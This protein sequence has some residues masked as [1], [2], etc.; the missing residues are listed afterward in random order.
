MKKT[1]TLPLLALL[2]PLTFVSTC[3]L[4]QFYYKDI[5]S[6]KLT[7][8]EQS[9]C[10]KAKVKKITLVSLDEQ[11]EPKKDFFCEKKISKDFR[12]N[13]VL[14]RTLIEGKSM[15]STMFNQK[16]YPTQTYDSSEHLVK[17]TIYSY[18][19]D[20]L[21]LSIITESVSKDDDFISTL[22]EAHQYLYDA[23]GKL[24]TL[25]VVIEGKPT[26]QIVFAY[27]ESGNVS[28]E[29]NSTTG[30][31]YYYYYDEQNRL[32]DVV[33]HSDVLEKLVL[34]HQFTYD[35]EGN[36]TRQITTE[37]GR[38]SFIVWKYTYDGSLKSLD[39]LYT[40]KGDL[41]GRIEYSYDRY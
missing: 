3:V 33:H 21:L 40:Q 39:E 4:G 15:M 31:V 34:D 26:N 17:K 35:D 41:L 38:N 12:K 13:T 20:T 2:L 14:T 10:A 5:F 8:A 24:T 6:V 11:G 37:R 23:Q 22:K 18:Q 16:G 7:A 25:D 9:A 19:D 32:T 29:K 28:I 1:C 27:D 30:L 36:I